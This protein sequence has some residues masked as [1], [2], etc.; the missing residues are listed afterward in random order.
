MM[1]MFFI[2]ILFMGILFFGFFQDI[3]FYKGE[4][5]FNVYYMGDV[6]FSYVSLVDEIFD[7]NVVYVVFVFGVKLDW[8]IY[9]KG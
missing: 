3:F 5:V 7:Y 9:L 4:K 2:V 6:W 1:K 8:Y